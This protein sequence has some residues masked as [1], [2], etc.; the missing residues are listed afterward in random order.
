V[1]TLRDDSV[2]ARVRAPDQDIAS[3][4][5]LEIT[6]A[7]RPDD[8]A[9]LEH[10]AV[11]RVEARL[12]GELPAAPQIGRFVV[13]NKIGAG[14]LGIVYAAYDPKL[15]RRVAIK[16]VHRRPEL[17]L[18]THRVLREAQALARLSHPH[19][20]AVHEVGE[21]QGGLF[22]AMELVEGLTLGEWASAPHDW[23][24]ALQPL[25]D[26]ARGLA[27]AHRAGIVHRDFKPAN[28]IVGHDG[29]A[30]VLDFGLARGATSAGALAIAPS[31][32]ALD[33]QL[34]QSGTLLGTPAY[35]APEQWRHD[36][37]DARAD[38]WAFCVTALEVLWGRRPFEGRDANALREHVLAG[39]IDKPNNRRAIPQAAE[40]VLLRG[41]A[42]DPADRHADLEKLIA[43]LERAVK[44]PRHLVRW[45]LL[46]LALLVIGAVAGVGIS[47]GART[48]VDTGAIELAAQQAR[49][50][51][52]A[53]HYVYP[54][55]DA[56]EADT[57]YAKLVA[58]E[59][60]TGGNAE[61]AHQQAAVLRDEFA[62]ALVELGDAYWARDDARPF[63]ID[64]YAAALLFDPELAHARE[65][66]AVTTGELALLR[67][68]ALTHDFTA[69]ELGVADA[70][71]ALAEPDAQ[72]RERKLGN[73]VERGGDALAATTTERLQRLGGARHKPTPSKRVAMPPSVTEA[74]VVAVAPASVVAP[75]PARSPAAAKALVGEARS[76]L[77]AGRF[78]S[79]SKTLHRALAL[80]P[81]SH[82]ARS[83]L[84]DL[85]FDQ[86]RY[87]E[88]AEHARQAIALAPKR[89]DYRMQL[90]D[91]YFKVLRYADA[92]AAY[93]KARALGSKQAAAALRR[94]DERLGTAKPG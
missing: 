89:A 82:A 18:D 14:G 53:G 5:D 71:V 60:M 41:L 9:A 34:T 92:R 21:H 49:A 54:P 36:A 6:R 46:G 12:F 66:A 84:S 2:T 74:P 27:A 59:A 62:A 79:A 50:A 91:A 86:G 78:A 61:Q 10:G 13:L 40:R 42:V 31:H 44:P 88:A 19:V 1:T 26:A 65:R 22:I 15:D 83:A 76:D 38:Q 39:T 37:I 25:L 51:A 64:F 7:R 80:D 29:R 75:A 32:S 20:V 56:P 23:R 63:A 30:R 67:Q 35:L 33:L 87:A 47:L 48:S 55:S 11:A 81:Q 73:V 72:V 90:G 52:A 70:L 69:S 3:S 93:D 28:V 4:E 68:R 8:D 77:R 43:A 58:L 17:G 57:A 16:V 45:G 85:D 24:T 94:I